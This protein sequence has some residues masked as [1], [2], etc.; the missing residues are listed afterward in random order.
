MGR[1]SIHFYSGFGPRDRT[2]TEKEYA[3]A[4]YGPDAAEYSIEVCRALI[5]KAVRQLLV[6]LI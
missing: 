4:V 3:R 5:N 6:Y 1:L 2:Q